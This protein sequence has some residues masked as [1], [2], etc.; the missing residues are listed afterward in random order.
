[1]VNFTLNLKLLTPSTP[2]FNEEWKLKSEYYSGVRYSAQSV[3]ESQE[4]FTF[5]V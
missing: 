3:N 2:T 1:M 5:T 4:G